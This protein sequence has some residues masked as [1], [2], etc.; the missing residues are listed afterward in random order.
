M[1]MDMS[2]ITVKR[3]T[4]T[5]IKLANCVWCDL[6]QNRSHIFDFSNYRCCRFSI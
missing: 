4:Y 1:V 3:G 5:F 2:S 6:S